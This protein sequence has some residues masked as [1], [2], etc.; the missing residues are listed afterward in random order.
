MTPDGKRT[1]TLNEPRAAVLLQL[2]AAFDRFAEEEQVA[3]ALGQYDVAEEAHLTGL[4]I[5]RAYH[6]ESDDPDVRP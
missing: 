3:I 1:E 6:A 4:V 5:L 2:A